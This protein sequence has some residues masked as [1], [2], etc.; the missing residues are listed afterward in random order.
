MKS[1][2][3]AAKRDSCDIGVIV[4]VFDGLVV[5]LRLACV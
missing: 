4:G 5:V 1:E 2:H 3:I